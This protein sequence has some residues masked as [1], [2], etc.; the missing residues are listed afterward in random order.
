LRGCTTAP[1]E[2]K[3]SARNHTLVS[4]KGSQCLAFALLTR[5]I[6]EQVRV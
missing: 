1:Q 3:K 5:Q 4:A 6:R 2:L